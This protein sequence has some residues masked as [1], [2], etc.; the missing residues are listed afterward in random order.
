MT[1]KRDG[2][3][4]PND[5][6][7]LIDPK[8]A[9]VIGTIVTALSGN[10]YQYATRPPEPVPSVPLAEYNKWVTQSNDAMIAVLVEK[11]KLQGQLDVCKPCKKRT[12]H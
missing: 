6:A 1:R 8:T 2:L 7:P 3:P 10:I 9:A 4:T 12:A 5:K 11:A